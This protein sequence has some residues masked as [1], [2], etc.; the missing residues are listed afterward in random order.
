MDQSVV[1]YRQQNSAAE[2]DCL[3]LG[4]RIMLTAE[5]ADQRIAGGRMT[6]VATHLEDKPNRKDVANNSKN[7]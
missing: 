5:I 6:I 1:G 3:R 2:V 7:Y 4:G